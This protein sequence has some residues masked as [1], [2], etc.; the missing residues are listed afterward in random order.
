MK[1]LHRFSKKVVKKLLG[2]ENNTYLCGDK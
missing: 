2:I 1:I